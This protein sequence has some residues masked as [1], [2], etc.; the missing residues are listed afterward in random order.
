MDFAPVWAHRDLLVEGVAAT[1]ALSIVSLVGALLIGVPVGAAGA[2]SVRPLRAAAIAYVESVRNVPLLLHIYA[3]YF[4]MDWLAIPAPLCVVLGMSIYFGAYAAEIVR[5]GLV[6]VPA[7]QVD[8]A[9]VLG[10]GRWRT[11]RLVVLPQAFR[12]MSPSLADLFSQLIRNS[13]LASVVGVG[14]VAYQ[15]GAIEADTFR[16]AETYGTVAAIY[17]LLVT[18]ASAAARQLPRHGDIMPHDA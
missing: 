13:S 16:G 12:I 7:G 14:E 2:S 18:L 15:A 1:I 4:G 10:L 5:A 3:W 9:R 17:L 11:L 8:A 6:A